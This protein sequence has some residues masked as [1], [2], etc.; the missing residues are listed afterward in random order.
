MR[1]YI[2]LILLPF[3]IHSS[4]AQSAARQQVLEAEKERFAAQVSKDYARLDKLISEDLYYIHSNGSVDTK[5]TFIGGIKDGSRSYEDITMEDTKVRVYH[6]RTAVINGLCTYLRTG[7]NGQP[8]N[9][10][11]HYTSVYVK[12]G[13]QWQMVSW[14]SFRIP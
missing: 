12:Q 5:S 11:L 4:V 2:L 3:S 9:L 14:Q 10:H 13:K 1:L 7:E 6:G 8:N